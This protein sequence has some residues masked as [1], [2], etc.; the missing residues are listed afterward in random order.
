MK[1]LSEV[2]R[3]E[4]I[5][6]TAAG[7]SLANSTRLFAE[8]HN[9]RFH[10]D[11]AQKPAASG[12]TP[13]PLGPDEAL[14]D[15]LDGNARFVKGQ[16]T[17]PRRSPEDFRALAEGQYPHAVIVSCADSRVAP[18]ILFDVGVGDIFVVRI[19]GNVI[20]APVRR[21]RAALNTPSPN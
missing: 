21:S 2:S 14:D 6:L 16:P 18:E 3:R 13:A 7:L 8:S 1:R 17:G 5:S 9:E 15:L 10:E 20:G 11:A 4:F 19:A 12:P